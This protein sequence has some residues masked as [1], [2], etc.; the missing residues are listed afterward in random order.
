MLAMARS[1][2]HLY[3]LKMSARHDTPLVR[4]EGWKSAIRDGH[5][6]QGSPENRH[7]TSKT[8]YFFKRLVPIDMEMIALH[9]PHKL[10]RI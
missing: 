4:S 7:K 10:S 6:R 1:L 2:T 5:D 3:P 8:Q 9:D